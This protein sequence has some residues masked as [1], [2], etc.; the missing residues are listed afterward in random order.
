M[1]TGHQVS[2]SGG[3]DVR[4]QHR[5]LREPAVRD[6]RRAQSAQPAGPLPPGPTRSTGE[7]VVEAIFGHSG[8]VSSGRTGYGAGADRTVLLRWYST[9]PDP[10]VKPGDWIADVTY[11]RKQL[12]VY[13]RVPSG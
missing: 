11:E 4:R 6:R 1:F 5:D 10:V 7:T 2:S 9:E 13:N 12:S 3:V 8:N